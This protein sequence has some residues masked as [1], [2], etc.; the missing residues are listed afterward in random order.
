MIVPRAE[1]GL[2]P[3]RTVPLPMKLPVREVWLHHS[4]TSPT[5]DPGADWRAI[6]EIGFSR[7]FSDISYSYGFHPDGTTL[8]GRGLNVGA[9][10]ADDK[11]SPG[12]LVD[13]NPISFGLVLIGDYREVEPTEAQ[14]QAVREWVAMA[15]ANGWIEPGTAIQPGHYPTG[16]HRDVFGTECPGDGAYRLLDRFREPIDSHPP[17]QEDDMA[18]TFLCPS[19]A[20]TE[21]GRTMT[22][23]LLRAGKKPVVRAFNNAP[24]DVDEPWTHTPVPEV[25]TINADGSPST[26]DATLDG[27]LQNDALAILEDEETGRVYVFAPAD[28]GCFSVAVRPPGW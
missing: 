21:Q 2:R 4:V 28:G 18:N 1:A 6:Q 24:L 15:E 10:T 25:P 17:V 8:I 13:R 19:W 26:Y 12:H 3:P 11:S 27:T 14:I 5:G 9:H 7:G 20:R 16:G 23:Q 22:Y